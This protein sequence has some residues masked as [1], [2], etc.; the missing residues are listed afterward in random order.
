[1]NEYLLEE[2][3]PST[4]ERIAQL[5]GGDILLFERTHKPWVREYGAVLFLN[6]GSVGKPKDGDPRAA[7]AL[8]EEQDGAVNVSVE[9]VSVE[10]AAYDVEEVAD[11]VRASGLP[12][13]LADQLVRARDGRSCRRLTPGRAS[14]RSVRVA[15]S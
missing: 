6:C 8:L 15:A 3:P 9:R 1:M 7:S 14:S 5:A 10:R 4:F 11:E 12:P 13:E 2:R